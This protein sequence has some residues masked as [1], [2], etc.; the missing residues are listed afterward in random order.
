MLFYLFEYVSVHLKNYINE[1]LGKKDFEII[2][3]L[4]APMDDFDD[5]VLVYKPAELFLTINEIDIDYKVLYFKHLSDKI[6]IKT[7]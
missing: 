6:V 7:K 5:N 1:Y 2:K 4:G 3:E